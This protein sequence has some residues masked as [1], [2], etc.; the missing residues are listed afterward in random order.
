M[1]SLTLCSWPGPASSGASFF[2]AELSIKGSCEE[3]ADFEC[4]VLC[5]AET[6]SEFS[7]EF[8]DTSTVLTDALGLAPPESTRLITTVSV[9]VLTDSLRLRLTPR[10]FILA[11]NL[12]RAVACEMLARRIVH[13]TPAEMLQTIM[14]CVPHPSLSTARH[15]GLTGFT[16]LGPGRATNTWSPTETIR[17]RRLL[18]NLPSTRGRCSSCQ[19]PRYVP[20][21]S[22]TSPVDRLY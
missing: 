19:A 5:T 11:E 12:T 3:R 14:S 15:S 9:C 4:F 13:Q 16:R 6:P 1:P 21:Q 2:C 22:L 18:W 20:L 8:L 10:F 7:S 17:H